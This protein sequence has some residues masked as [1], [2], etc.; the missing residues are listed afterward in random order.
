MAPESARVVVCVSAGRHPVSGRPCRARGDAAAV[1][2]AMRLPSTRPW[3]LHVGDPHEPA[4]REYLGLGLT[5]IEVTPADERVDVLPALLARLRSEPVDAV[6]TGPRAERGEG[7]GALPYA[8]ADGLG[9]PLVSGVVELERAGRTWQCVRACSGGR[10]QRLAVD[11]PAVLTAAPGVAVRGYA[12]AR[13]LAGRI[14]V[15]ATRDAWPA[16]TGR[17]RW[18]AQPPAVRPRHVVAA[19]GADRLS[20]L[21][22]PAGGGATVLRDPSPAEAAR[23]VLDWLRRHGLPAGDRVR[24]R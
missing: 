8:L 7:S 12:Y 22:T 15:V 23:A 17:D 5:S 11:G 1:E 21:L 10:R 2:L 9:W 6:L 13:A 14:E 4:L 24:E 19:N 20:A 18:R 3:A 16:D